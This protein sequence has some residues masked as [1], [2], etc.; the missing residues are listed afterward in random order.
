MAGRSAAMTDLHIDGQ[1][2]TGSGDAF[3]II[4]PATE[5]LIDSVPAASTAQIDDAVAA[6]GA[7]FPAWHSRSQDE[8]STMLR[9]V[10]SAIRDRSNEL[11]DALT[12]ETGRARARNLFYVEYTARVFDQYAELA[13]VQ[14]GRVAPANEPGQLSLVLRVPYG[15]VAALVPWNY[16]LTL[17]GFKAA[18]ALAVGNTLVIK[19]APE[20][21]LTTLLLADVFT[22]QLPAGV[23]NVIAGGAEVGAGLVEHDGVHL[24]AFTGSTATGRHIGAACG[25]LVK[26]A[27]LELSGKD[28]A[29]VF[30]DVNPRDAAVG[31][32]WAAFLNAGQ[33]CT[34][35][36]RA[37][38]HEDVYEE[39]TERVVSLAASLRVGDPFD[40]KT[41]IGPMRSER[42]RRRVL[43]QLASANDAGAEILVGGE[44]LAGPGFFLRPTVVSGVD[45]EMSLMRDETFGP[46]LPV[47][48]FSD[49]DEAFRLAADTYYGL[50]ASIYT[51]D[52][53]RVRR[54][55]EEMTVGNVW[56]N[57]PVVDN[58]GAP[59]GGMRGSGDA[60]ELGTEALDSF[61]ATRHV[62]WNIDLEIK[63]W[64]YQEED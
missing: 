43:E 63:P 60:R 34:S 53:T 49:E 56:I 16:P 51:R 11:A 27:R 59:F 8:R 14:G 5:Q 17:L 7:A 31:V 48:P 52:P 50:G 39:F 18:P 26:P 46:V 22:E 21:T 33:V 19:P 47:V 24:V 62:H 54:A 42:G 15:V 9:S 13:R 61:T 55:Y 6:A 12:Q 35:T 23:V 4:D 29:I 3:E 25:G 64:W 2:V 1:R 40:P 32:A 38:V 30:P 57:D 45:H 20:T 36:E 37:Y 44:P 58:L 41:Q 28:P 10:A